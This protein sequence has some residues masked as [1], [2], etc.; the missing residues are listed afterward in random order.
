MK[1]NFNFYAATLALSVS[2]FVANI[3]Q[4]RRFHATLERLRTRNEVSAAAVQPPQL[5][6]WH[7]SRSCKE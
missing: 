7:L 4:F 5:T 3:L 2:I 1:K 6:C